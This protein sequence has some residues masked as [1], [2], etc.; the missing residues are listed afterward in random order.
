MKKVFWS[1]G[2]KVEIR[3][4]AFD[5]GKKFTIYITETFSKPKPRQVQSHLDT[6]QNELCNFIQHFKDTTNIEIKNSYT[7]CWEYFM[8]GDLHV[9]FSSEP[10][11][12]DIET[13]TSF[14]M[15]RW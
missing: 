2:I 6:F 13:L 5:C 7:E 1:G 8:H 3:Y 9:Q 14:G 12:S 11:E 4:D 15:T 10:I